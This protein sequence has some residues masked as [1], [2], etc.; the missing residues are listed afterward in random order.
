M[1]TTIKLATDPRRPSSR[2]A[3]DEAAIDR[4]ANEGGA[5]GGRRVPAL[6]GESHGCDNKPT[7]IELTT[8]DPSQRLHGGEHE[9]RPAYGNKCV[10]LQNFL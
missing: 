9:V 5:M 8:I 1:F 2:Y 6:V 7:T 4:W 10:P 3:T